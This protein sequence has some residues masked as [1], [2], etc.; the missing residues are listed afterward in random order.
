MPENKSSKI[1]KKL[2]LNDDPNEIDDE[3]TVTL[4]LDDGS[5][6]VCAV[7]TILTLENQ[8]YIALL[9]LEENGEANKEGEVWFYRCS[10]DEDDDDPVLDYIDSDDEYERVAEAF[11]EFLDSVEFDALE[12]E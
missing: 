3:I 1:D 7:V 8:D 10:A 2:L 9:P 6:V 12:E 5:T 4:D 11:D